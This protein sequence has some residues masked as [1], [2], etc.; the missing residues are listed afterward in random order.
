MAHY[1]EPYEPKFRLI[2]TE[3]ITEKVSK[4]GEFEV[5]SEFICNLFVVSDEGKVIHPKLIDEYPTFSVSMM[6]R[7]TPSGKP[8]LFN[9]EVRGNTFRR[10]AL[11][12][13]GFRTE[14]YTDS[15]PL[16]P[17]QLRFV[18]DF[19]TLLLR[20]AVYEVAEHWTYT[21]KGRSITWNFPITNKKKL[22]DIESIRLQKMVE[23]RMTKRLDEDFYKDFA[24][25]YQSFERQSLSPIKELEKEYPD[26]DH[27]T[28][29]RYAT[30]CR[31][32]GY[33]PKIKAGRPSTR[34]NN[35]AQRKG[36]D[37]NTKKAKGR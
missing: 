3:P 20:R 15:K 24:I 4:V 23:K 18:A 37:G 16:T 8:E 29:Q 13:I 14:Y 2:S 36:K 9:F 10:S 12:G 6:I 11:M 17:W 22:N 25:H 26:K 31:E 28:I 5:P 27:R 21:K 1:Q 34:R 33:L 7:V 32:L 19:R 35:K 30:K